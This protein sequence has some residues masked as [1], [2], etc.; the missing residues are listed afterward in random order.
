LNT[1]GTV[2]RA[3]LTISA[4]ERLS[5]AGPERSRLAR[6]TQDSAQS[7]SPNDRK[8]PKVQ[9]IPAT[10]DTVS[11]KRREDLSLMPSRS[12]M[13]HPLKTAPDRTVHAAKDAHAEKPPLYSM[14]ASVISANL[15]GNLIPRFFFFANSP[16]PLAR[17]R[18]RAY[19]TLVLYNRCVPGTGPEN[20]PVPGRVPAVRTGTGERPQ[21]L[22]TVKSEAQDGVP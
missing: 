11:T 9:A 22:D 14:S 5:L 19:Q 15:E 6:D 16:I 2:L 13:M 21:T 8:N 7:I 12:E 3:S 17:F 1:I 10:I 20:V 18:S 4:Y